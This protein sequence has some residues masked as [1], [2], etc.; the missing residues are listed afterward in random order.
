LGHFENLPL[1]IFENIF[2][3][4]NLSQLTLLRSISKRMTLTIDSLSAY[5][6]IIT[7][8][9]HAL[10]ALLSTLTARYFTASTLSSALRSPSCFLC[11]HLGTYL[12]LLTCQRICWTCLCTSPAILPISLAC[13]KRIFQ[14]SPLAHP[15]TPILLTLPGFYS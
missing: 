5:R 10:R 6:Q 15:T 7:H 3:H 1:E 13:A 2:S 8:A 14:F 4:L 12:S 11:G 9:P